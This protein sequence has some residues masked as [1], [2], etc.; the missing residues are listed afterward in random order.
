[1]L[2]WNKLQ[3][4]LLSKGSFPYRER[5]GGEGKGEESSSSLQRDV[6]RIVAEEDMERRVTERRGDTHTHTHTHMQRRK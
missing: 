2:Q 4:V 6:D 5:G 3:E 1:M